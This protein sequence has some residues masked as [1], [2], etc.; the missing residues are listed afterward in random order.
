MGQ[1]LGFGS[2]DIYKNAPNYIINFTKMPLLYLDRV[3]TMLVVCSRHVG[4]FD[5]PTLRGFGMSVQPTLR[6]L[7]IL[8]FSHDV[9]FGLER[10]HLYVFNLDYA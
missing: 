9:V 7:C 8:T 1:S 3:Q 10:R 5:T 6:L 4:V 2:F